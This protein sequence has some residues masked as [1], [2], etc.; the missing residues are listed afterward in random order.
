MKLQIDLISRSVLATFGIVFCTFSNAATISVTFVNTTYGAWPQE[1]KASFLEAMYIWEQTIQS[2]QVINVY[3]K[4]EDFVAKEGDAWFADVLGYARPATT[5]KNFSS[6]DPRYYQDFFYPLSLAEKLKQQEI[7]SS[8]FPHEIICSFNSTGNFQWHFGLTNCP[9]NKQDFIST[10]LHEIGHGI[11]FFSNALQV[12][13][14]SAAGPFIGFA[15]LTIYD[16]YIEDGYGKSAKWFIDNPAH[17][18]G[19]LCTQYAT[20]DNLFFTGNSATWNQTWSNVGLHPFIHAPDPWEEGSSISH[21]Y[22]ALFNDPL[23]GNSLM[24]PYSQLGECQRNPGWVGFGL[25]QDIGWD[26]TLYLSSNSYDEE[27][28]IV[29]LYPNPTSRQISISSS[30]NKYI[31]RI[32]LNDVQGRNVI[33]IDNNASLYLTLGV[34]SLLPGIYFTSIHFEDGSFTTKSFVKK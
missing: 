33:S 23:D 34:E 21:F 5:V 10:V 24:T 22:E 30:G 26:G 29:S 25:L 13:V 27:K 32:E 17:N 14:N 7:N 2:T 18:F 15:N 3:A 28:T 20:S 12:T 4:F 9:N 19:L 31:T 8:Q 1:A 6:S 16:K 11:G